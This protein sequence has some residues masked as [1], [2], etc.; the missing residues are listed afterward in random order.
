M[1]S[2][3][4]RA[5]IHPEERRQASLLGGRGQKHVVHLDVPNVGEESG[6]IQRLHGAIAS[7]HDDQRFDVVLA[8]HVAVLEKDEDV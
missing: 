2:S 3:P 8:I 4:G 6:K 1:R 5:R 7:K